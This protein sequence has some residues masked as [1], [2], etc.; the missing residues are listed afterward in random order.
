MGAKVILTFFFVFI[1]VSILLNRWHFYRYFKENG[2]NVNP[3][4]SIRNV[5]VSEVVNYHIE[6]STI[7]GEQKRELLFLR[8]WEI[9]NFCLFPVFLI[10]AIALAIFG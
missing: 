2:L 7:S 4:N 9:F 5:T 6:N 10:I 1:I 8:R 3:T